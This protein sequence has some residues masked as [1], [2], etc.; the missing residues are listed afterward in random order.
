M[1]G[2]PESVLRFV[3]QKR[4]SP[5]RKWWLLRIQ[6]KLSWA[7]APIIKC[8]YEIVHDFVDGAGASRKTKKCVA[9]FG[10]QEIVGTWGEL[11][12]RFARTNSIHSET[13]CKKDRVL[14]RVV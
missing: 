7:P 6:N 11:S 10:L 1:Q 4:S 8:F 14:V 9:A 5:T 3:A 2:C 12:E 13:S